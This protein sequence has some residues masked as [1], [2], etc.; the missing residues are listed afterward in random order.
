MNKRRGWNCRGCCAA[1]LALVERWLQVSHRRRNRSSLRAPRQTESILPGTITTEP[2]DSCAGD[3]HFVVH[4]NAQGPTG[5]QGPQGPEGPQGPQGPEGP[6]GPEGPQG[7]EG[8]R[9]AGWTDRS[10]RANRPA[11]TRGTRRTRRTPRT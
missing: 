10:D 11:R 7:P 6:E 8:P 5:P 9:R 3:G 4:W 2:I 1:G